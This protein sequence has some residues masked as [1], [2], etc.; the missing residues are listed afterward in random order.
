MKNVRTWWGK[1]YIEALE[2]FI[3]AGRLAR[4]KG[5]ANESRIKQWAMEGN[6]IS[7]EIRG[8]ANPYFGVYKEPL[9]Q[10]RI[11]LRPID[12]GDWKEVI[13]Q[14]GSQAAFISRLLLNE[15]PDNIEEPF[16]DL[17]LHLLPRNMKD[18]K[19][20]CSCPDYANP[21]KHIAGLD[22]FIAAKLD[23]DPFL[24]FELRGLPRAELS[25]QL[26]ETPL[27]RALS[28]AMSMEELPLPV[29]ASFFTRPL[30]Q[31]FPGTWSPEDFWRGPM[32]LPEQVEPATP[33]SVAALT[34]KKGGDYPEFWARDNS[35]IE[36][37]EAF[38]EAVRKRSKEW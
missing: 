31:A 22:Y 38:Y 15:V 34:V 10:T 28:Q 18:L 35:F 6:C 13:R 37:M 14:L 5:Y 3:D 8:N 30:A 19:T 21:C 11:E 33:P 9:Y 12:A 36:A 26:L 4:G 27:G 2:G 24:L 1:K 20:R 16:E 23:Q 25:R 29:S 32:R 17:G 7:A